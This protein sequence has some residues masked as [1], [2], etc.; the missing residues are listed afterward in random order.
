MGT[1]KGRITYQLADR[2]GKWTA[3]SKQG[4][5]WNGGAREREDKRGARKE[6][7]EEIPTSDLRAQRR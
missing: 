2:R 1:F 4:V 5:G 3:L 7:K 6:A